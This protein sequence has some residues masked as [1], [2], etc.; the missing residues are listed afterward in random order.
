MRI[1]FSSFGSLFLYTALT[2]QISV[3][4][5]VTD[6]R[7]SEPVPGAHVIVEQSFT[8]AYTDAEG[9]FSLQKVKPADTIVLL[10][11]HVSYEHTRFELIA[12]KR[13][14]QLNIVLQPKQIMSEQVIVS[15][16]RADKYTPTTHTRVSR[17]EIEKLNLG[18][19]IPFLL[20]QTP[21]IV[22]TSD[23][24]AGIGYTS[25]RI[26]GSD[27]TRINVT[28]NGI[29]LNDAESQGVFWVD[30]PDLASSV[31][32]IQIQ[33]GVGTS[34]NGAAAFGATVDLQTV[35][36]ADSAY[37]EWM[38]SFGS[39]NTVKNTLRLG[40]GLLKDKFSFDGRL[41]HIRSDGYIDR[42]SSKLMSYFL[43]G[44]YFGEKTII[45]LLHFSGKETTYQ[46]WWGVPE[47][48]L[49]TNRTYNYYNYP[50]ETDNYMQAHY[51]LLI[52]Q[53]LGRRWLVNVAGHYTRGMGYY[54]QYKGPE[55]NNDLGFNSPQKFSYYGLENVIISSDTIKHTSLIRRRHLDNHFYGC[56]YSVKY[57]NLKRLQTIL[58]GGWNRY[59]GKHFGEIIWAQFASNGNYGHRFYDND[60][61]KTDFHIFFKANYRI[62]RHFSVFAD[63]QYRR[64][65]YTIEGIDIGLIYLHRQ[66]K[67][68]FVNP[69]AG[70]AW[71]INS[72]NNVY[73]SFAVGNR[74]PV[75]S[76]FIDNP[77]NRQPKHET[78]YN[79]E[80]GYQFTSHSFA[81]LANYYL[82]YYRNQLVLTGQLNDVGAAIRTNVPISYRTGIELQGQWN[83]FKYLTWRANAAYSVNK[84]KSFTEYLYIYDVDYN[85][86][87]IH[88]QVLRNRDISFSPRIVAGST[89]S[90]YLL[91]AMEVSL[92]SKYVGKQYLDNTQNES[93]KLD[94]YWVNNILI[95]Y[96]LLPSVF[97]KSSRFSMR[98]IR[99]QVLLN[100]ILNTLY[101]NNGYTFSEVYQDQENN[102]TRVDYNYYYPQ[103]GF[104]FLIGLGLL[105]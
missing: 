55:Y 30:L 79:V 34:T 7:T 83:I 25:M 101:E 96:S 54:E 47:D 62:H 88:T 24:G 11:S 50:N 14:E 100:N 64:V 85:L 102:R 52:S 38:N 22:T 8:G 16:I 92:I 42:A 61:L 21:N 33:R 6:A 35:H 91:K 89:L 5:K 10:I 59:E 76:D 103:A 4:G 49:A 18:Q 68:H 57:D 53:Q 40:S 3:S 29:P 23:A 71:R 73:T 39:F 26:R 37:A 2:A 94:P 41:S 32:N 90:A 84:I 80:T 51:Q 15:S 43:S 69:K 81:F 1:F 95:Q 56:T 70:F 60:G 28:I 19:D 58:G 36:A 9:M 75:R 67:Y 20:D 65:H 87:G 77:N 27:Q 12:D 44:G 86:V 66:A 74:E 98:E 46:A 82:M 97:N 31:E 63:M 93:R 13:G 104:N 99:I 48:S 45:K 78:L 17:E 105:F 72:R